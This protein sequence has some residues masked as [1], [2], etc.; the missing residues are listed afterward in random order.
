MTLNCLTITFH[1]CIKWLLGFPAWYGNHDACD[2]V[3]ILT[4]PH[5]INIE[6]FKFSFRI[7]ESTSPCLTSFKHFLK[8]SG[9][10]LQNANNICRNCYG[11]SDFLTND[12][13]SIISRVQ[14][15]QDSEV[16]SDYYQSWARN[17]LC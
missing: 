11:I 16:R 5:R 15:V 2:K 3:G 1:K 9:I 14:R 6:I 10:Y 17:A 13:D 12:I 4:L 8:A 7:L